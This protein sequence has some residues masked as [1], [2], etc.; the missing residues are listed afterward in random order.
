MPLRIKITPCNNVSILW[1]I[2]DICIMKTEVASFP[3]LC[4]SIGN[5]RTTASFQ[6]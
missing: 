2:Q 3:V 4:K 5:Q 1:K 6:K